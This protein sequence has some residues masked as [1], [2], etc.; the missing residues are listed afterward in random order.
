[1]SLVSSLLPTVDLARG[2]LDDVGL[3]PFQVFVRVRAW[4]G[5]LVGVGTAT[6]TETEITVA[7]TKRPKVVEVKSK[8]VIA[9]GGAISATTYKVGPLTP[10]Y[11]TGGTNAD[12]IDPPP[13]AGQE[14][15]FIVKGPGLPT[16]GVL[17]KR[18]D[19]DQS[20]PFRW[21]LTLERIGQ[22]A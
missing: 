17:C 13:V 12:T 7:G 19:G 5:A 10:D 6:D 22:N 21:M 14:V 16:A 20:S 3:R 8:D 11:G 1:M 18:V 2:L 15:L 4:S 9:S